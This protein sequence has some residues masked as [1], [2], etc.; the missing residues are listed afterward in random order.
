MESEVS[1]PVCALFGLDGFR[2]LGAAEAGGEVELLIET[3]ADLVGCPEC[4]AVARPKDRRPTWVRDL[5]I[6]NRPVLLCWWKRVWCCPHELCPKRNWTETHEVIAP[7]AVLTERARRWAFEQVGEHDATV[8][9]TAVA[10]G[11]AWSTVWS[12]VER[13][14]RPVVDDQARLDPPQQP[15]TAVGVDETSFLRACGCPKL[16]A[17]HATC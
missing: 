11:V 14:G 15:V 2:L 16:G 1:A 3:P 6:A 7:R 8:S 12:Q 13:L 17:P 10:L 9:Q 4:G 5:P